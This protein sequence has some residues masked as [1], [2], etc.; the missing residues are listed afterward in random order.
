M[1]Y[2]ETLLAKTGP[3]ARVWLAANVERKV[4][5]KDVLSSDLNDS[6]VAISDRGQA[7]LA[8]RL[9]GQLLLGVVRIYSRKT[10]YLLDDCNEAILKIKMAF[11]P[12]NVDLPANQSHTASA[13]A[14]NL[15]DVLTEIDLLGPG[16]DPSL[17]LLQDE[18]PSLLLDPS[19]N[20][21]DNVERGRGSSVLSNGFDPSSSRLGRPIEIGRDA[22]RPM[23]DDSTMIPDD[24][25]LDD[26]GIQFEDIDEPLEPSKPT[27]DDTTALDEFAPQP[28]DDEP[29]L[30]DDAPLDTVEGPLRSP[31]A[32]FNN[33]TSA[34]LARRRSHSR[35]ES[36]LSNPRESVEREL[37][38][39]FCARESDLFTLEDD[40]SFQ[41]PQRA[42]KKRKI[43]HAD[44]NTQLRS[45]QIRNQQEDRSKILKPATF[46]PRDPVLLALMEMQRNGSF[47]SNILGD[48]LSKGWA[49]ELRGVLSLEVVRGTSDL[50]R[51][52]D[53]GVAGVDE[54][55]SELEI[56]EDD[57]PSNGE[58]HVHFEEPHQDEGPIIRIPGDEEGS[59]E[60]PEDEPLDS[61]ENFDETTLPILH[62]ADSGPVSLGTKHA[63]HLLRD[64]L[65]GSDAEA[66]PSKRVQ[67]SVLFTD[68]CPE[69]ST[70]RAD[71]TKMFFETLVLA[72]KD[73]V[74]VEQ[75]TQEKHEMGGPLRVRA[76]RGLWGDWAEM[77]T[78]QGR[79]QVTT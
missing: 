47:V 22:T 36:V 73:A 3:L 41:A 31:S 8:L 25:L 64:K 67:N 11:R 18:D 38:R 56:P 26:A 52:R 72:T 59:P 29:M 15:P 58:P 5:K 7:P 9:S 55:T 77:G 16:P 13:A 60:I 30:L 40:Q 53:S 39:S 79:E 43:L 27:H 61:P 32:D 51:K 42:A 71:A 57:L 50:K 68:L 12:G 37:E 70:S 2:S 46:L 21:Q 44:V 63:V 4:T 35:S 54:E 34:P 75:P 74:K 23:A 78:E 49:P 19:Q 17:L 20:L 33:A 28:L 10:R 69:R 66:S 65:G 6:I 14:L 62:P 76:K 48:G 1:F 24:Q 45:E